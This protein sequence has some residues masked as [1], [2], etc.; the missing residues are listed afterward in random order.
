M[1]RP[2]VI[3]TSEVAKV[4]R[5]MER[6]VADPKFREVTK[7]TPD[8]LALRIR[9]LWD[10]SYK[11]SN[12]L[13]QAYLEF[14]AEHERVRSVA[15]R[16]SAP[17]HPRF[18]AWRHRQ[19]ERCAT[20]LPAATAAALIHHPA[21]FELAKGC[22]VGCWFCGISAPMLG[23]IWSYD[24]NREF[25]VDVLKLLR[26]VLG[27]A[28]A[29]QS[30][31]YWATDPFD[32]PDYEHFC[33]DFHHA[34]GTFPPTTTALAARFPERARSLLELSHSKG[35]RRNRFS[36]LSLGQLRRIHEEFS[37]DDLLYTDLALQNK[38]TLV[39]RASAGRALDPSSDFTS[40]IAC[41]SGFLLNMVEGTIKLIS[42][43]RANDRWPDGYRIHAEGEFANIEQLQHQM[44]RMTSEQLMPPR[45][46]LDFTVRFRDDLVYDGDNLG[47]SHA[48]LE[49]K[50]RKLADRIAEGTHTTMEIATV[51]EKDW[52][53]AQTLYA[54]NELFERGLLDDCPGTLA[55]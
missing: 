41:I 49:I 6:F 10:P 24:E 52:P 26:S 5:F 9:P 8:E 44:A 12:D 3:G 47:N 17:I 23:E 43:C 20:E 55:P 34:L 16:D 22:S 7:T 38:G 37:E 53:L 19:I 35:Q 14:R 29:G 2:T 11:T 1:E 42:P 13:L 51:L 36:I 31:C 25:W 21:T 54:I 28:A 15:R 48:R 50:N 18:R 33:R 45:I 4:K 27:P 39:Q 40:T 30:F 46:P 32:N